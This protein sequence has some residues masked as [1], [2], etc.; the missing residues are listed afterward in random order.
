VGTALS[1]AANFLLLRA[2]F[3]PLEALERTVDAVRRGDA[4]A[5]VARV[6]PGDPQIAQ[7]AQTVDDMLDT[8]ARQQER[9]EQLS[10]AILRAQEEERARI[11]RDL[12]DQTAQT[13]TS[14]L[15]RL[16]ALEGAGDPAVRAA[17]PELLALTTAAL[18][19]VRRMAL[20]LRPA[21]LD[22]L[23]LA[24]ALA[25][26]AEQYRR[27]L[28]VPVTFHA[29]RLGARL[30]PE[31]ELALYRIAQEALANAARHAGAR[32]IRVELAPRD[33]HARLVVEDDGQGFDPDAVRARRER[34]LGLY[35]MQ[36]RAALVGGSLH[37]ESQPGGGTR[38]CADVA[39]LG[40]P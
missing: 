25:E 21:L 8:L 15:L 14:L 6:P 35:G 22:D 12:H 19:D 37:L 9:A 17:T 18:E 3:R 24:P 16:S 36:E 5:R 31:A 11:S 27:R 10:S 4:R 7:L 30:A 20:E 33:G 28:G 34:G 26:M 1:V 2:A 32:A 40:R 13:L 39:M 29:E 38:V 23:G